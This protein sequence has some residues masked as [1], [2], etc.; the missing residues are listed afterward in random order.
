MRN[1]IVKKSIN[2]LDYI[3]NNKNDI[4]RDEFKKKRVHSFAQKTEIGKNRLG[5]ENINK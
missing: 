1:L 3:Y 5:D 4:K 2:Y